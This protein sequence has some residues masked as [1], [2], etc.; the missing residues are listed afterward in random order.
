MR[1]CK[2]RFSRGKHLC[3]QGFLLTLFSCA[4]PVQCCVCVCVCFWSLVK[5]WHD[6]RWWLGDGW[7]L[8]TYMSHITKQ[9]NRSNTRVSPP[10]WNEFT[11]YPIRHS[12]SA[13]TDT[14]TSE[15]NHDG[16]KP[17]L[18]EFAGESCQS[19]CLK[20]VKRGAKTLCEWCFFQKRRRPQVF[21]CGQKIGFVP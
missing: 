7:A 1:H 9:A 2:S 14:D 4:C 3:V 5:A 20:S 16:A 18:N 8:D 12:V 11:F 6:E 17:S 21:S 13:D 15:T 19:T 10:Q